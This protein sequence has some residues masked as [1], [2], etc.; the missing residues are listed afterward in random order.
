MPSLICQHFFLNAMTSSKLH[1][2]NLKTKISLDWKKLFQKFKLHFSS[3]FKLL[4]KKIII[5]KKIVF[6]FPLN[7]HFL[8]DPHLVF[9]IPKENWCHMVILALFAN[10][11]WKRCLFRTESCE[12]KFFLELHIPFKDAR[13]PVVNKVY[14]ILILSLG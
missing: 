7:Y 8:I 11:N 10:K 3:F 12:N 14:V 1:F 6:T 13:L 4:D 2:E 5:M 9:N